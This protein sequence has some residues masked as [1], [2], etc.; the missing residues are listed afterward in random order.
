M[1][2]ST[3]N[4][5]THRERLTR[6]LAHTAGGPV[7]VARGAVGLSGAAVQRGAVELRRRYRESRLADHV[8]EAAE[9]AARELA[10][11]G[12]VVS[13]L[14]DVLAYGE[15]RRRRIRRSWVIAGAAGAALA[16]G[17]VAVVLIRRSGRPE[18]SSPR[19]P[20]VEAQHKV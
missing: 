10:A 8:A 1:R 7:D 13:A 3:Q 16:V 20:S 4:Q 17:A 14:P 19:P 9:A 12:E 5:L 18:E 15:P 6:G 2:L 11:A